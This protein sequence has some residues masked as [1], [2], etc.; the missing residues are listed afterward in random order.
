MERSEEPVVVE[1]RPWLEGFEWGKRG[2]GDVEEV[3]AR[4]QNQAR[5]FVKKESAGLQEMLMECEELLCNA[6]DALR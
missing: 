2:E 5:D 6:D 1:S 3:R 4:A